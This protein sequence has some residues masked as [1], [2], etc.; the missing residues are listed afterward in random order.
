MALDRVLEDAE[1]PGANVHL[2]QLL[3]WETATARLYAAV[4]SDPPMRRILANRRLKKE[5]TES[6]AAVKMM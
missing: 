2:R 6:V 3:R 1:K 5:I 4:E